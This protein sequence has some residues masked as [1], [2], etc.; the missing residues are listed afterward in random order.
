MANLNQ[1]QRIVICIGLGLILISFLF[2]AYEGVSRGG[3]GYRTR[4]LGYHFIFNP[5]TYGGNNSVIIFSRYLIQI[6]TIGIL[7]IGLVVLLEKP[8]NRNKTPE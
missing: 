7:S 2:P 1:N 6:F 8:I 4:F 5:P 3:G